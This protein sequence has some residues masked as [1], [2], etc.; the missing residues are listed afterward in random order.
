M[1]MQPVRNRDREAFPRWGVEG[2][3]KREYVVIAVAAAL[4]AAQN[5]R[6]SQIAPLAVQTADHVL[7]L[8]EMEDCRDRSEG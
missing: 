6:L 4:A 3:T 8:M 7:D 2:L 5:V 1:N